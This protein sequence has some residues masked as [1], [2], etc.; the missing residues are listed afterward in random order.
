MNRLLVITGPTGTSKTNLAITLAKDTGAALL[1][2][3]QLH[4]YQHLVDGTGLDLKALAQ[5]DHFGYQTL[6]P[7]V[8]SGPGPYM[9]WLLPQVRHLLSDRPLILE[10]G[11][12]S[13]LQ[14]LLSHKRHPV[15]RE[16]RFVAL[17]P[18]D[19]RESNTQQVSL[20][21][22]QTKFLSI[23]SETEELVRAGF[24]KPSGLPLLTECEMLW[25]HPEHTDSNLAWA[26][27]ISAK[28]YLPAYL[29]LL[30]RLSPEEARA[31]TIENVIQIQEYQ[32][33]RI[34]SLL[35]LSCFV[36]QSAVGTSI[37]SLSSYLVTS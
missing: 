1:P 3:D 29:A 2:L 19:N 16:I 20:R 37:E 7:W 17:M 14:A 4:R 26:I 36:P 11:C 18:D 13:Y 6:S 22:S 9:A 24:I 28:I 15:F 31:K 27:R 25:K 10:G 30:G 5:V 33:D 32:R 21:V 23:V 8:V 12:T 35:P 34:R